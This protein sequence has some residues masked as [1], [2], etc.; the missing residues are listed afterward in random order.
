MSPGEKSQEPADPHL[1]LEQ[2]TF[3]WGG[4][5]LRLEM[6]IRTLCLLQL[7]VS[8]KHR[9]HMFWYMSYIKCTHLDKLWHCLYHSFLVCKTEMSVLLG[10]LKETTDECQWHCLRKEYLV[11]VCPLW[12]LPFNH[13]AQGKSVECLSVAIHRILRF[14]IDLGVRGLCPEFLHG[15]VIST[16]ATLCL[17]HLFLEAD[18]NC[19]KPKWAVYAQQRWPSAVPLKEFLVPPRKPASHWKT[20]LII[21]H[22]S[23]RSHCLTEVTE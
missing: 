10:R 5:L 3:L 11:I 15:T 1:L 18:R 22:S 6:P 16:K 17:K 9:I 12:K 23:E 19:C 7:W 14:L 8:K 20:W 21:T 2:A 4:S 13:L